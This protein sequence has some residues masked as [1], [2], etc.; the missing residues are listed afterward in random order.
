MVFIQ[1]RLLRCLASTKASIVT[2]SYCLQVAVVALI[3]DWDGLPFVVMFIDSFVDDVTYV[4]DAE[5]C[6]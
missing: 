5:V 3:V 6:M 2:V 4:R 1:R